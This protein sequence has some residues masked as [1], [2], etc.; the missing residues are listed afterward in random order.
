MEIVTVE[1]LRLYHRVCLEPH[2]A[3]PRIGLRPTQ[4]GRGR[5][6]V[7]VSWRLEAL[8]AHLD[9]RKRSYERWM[10]VYVNFWGLIYLSSQ[11]EKRATSKGKSDTP[12]C[13]PFEFV[14]SRNATR[15]A[16]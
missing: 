11:A 7:G 3:D 13:R 16:S 5:E 9:A 15:R 12:T 2:R 10:S 4:R 14:V 6:G 1:G 8:W